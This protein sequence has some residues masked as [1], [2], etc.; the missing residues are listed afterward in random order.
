[1]RMVQTGI[2]YTRVRHSDRMGECHSRTGQGAWRETTRW[3]ALRIR[4]YPM[5]GLRKLAERAGDR[6]EI[7][8]SGHSCRRGGSN[9]G[10]EAQERDE[11]CGVLQARNT[12]GSLGRETKGATNE[13]EA[14]SRP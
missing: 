9:K 1:M 13:K 5:H 12:Q 8:E 11:G 3:E 14:E 4:A 2:S 7:P 10:E 6:Q